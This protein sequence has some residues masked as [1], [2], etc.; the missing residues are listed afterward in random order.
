MGPVVY[1]EKVHPRGYLDDK[2]ES[3]FV[4]QGGGVREGGSSG[5]EDKTCKHLAEIGRAHV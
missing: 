1:L 3:V 4:N 2:Q 5:R